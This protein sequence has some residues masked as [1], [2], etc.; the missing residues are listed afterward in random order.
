MKAVIMKHQ[1]VKRTTERAEIW[2][3]RN[4]ITYTLLIGKENGTAA[5][6]NK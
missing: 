4:W 2:M 6:E 5:M 3:Q 1:K